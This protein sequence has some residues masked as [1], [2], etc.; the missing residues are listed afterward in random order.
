M[1]RIK[2]APRRV[3]CDTWGPLPV[4]VKRQRSSSPSSDGSAAEENRSAKR[5][6]GDD[7]DSDDGEE[8]RLNLPAYILQSD[9]LYLCAVRG[10]C[11][12]QYWLLDSHGK[13]E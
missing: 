5:K 4:S 3:W 11:A 12:T 7:D 6:Q 1:A 9:P 13:C 10:V 2:H 8:V